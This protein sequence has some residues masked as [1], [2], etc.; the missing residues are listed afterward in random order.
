[1]AEF[2]PFRYNCL[3]EVSA[4]APIRFKLPI[5]A[6]RQ[7]TIPSK[8]MELLSL[9]QGDDLFLEIDGEYA[10]LQPA[11]SVSRSELPDDLWKKFQS[12]RG[13]KPTDIPLETFL[14]EVMPHAAT[15]NETVRAARSA[16][17]K[18]SRRPITAADSMG[19]RT[20]AAKA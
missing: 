8:A 16:S 19:S 15:P 2:P 20:A 7:V 3:V 5:G 6:K 13:A 14:A 12:R 9:Q 18:K 10:V 17:R 1:L 11:V 4:M